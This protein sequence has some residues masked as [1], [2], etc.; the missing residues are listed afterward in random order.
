[1]KSEARQSIPDECY[2]KQVALVRTGLALRP[3]N[4]QSAG[5]V[6]REG[7]I[8]QLD[9]LSIA[10]YPELSDGGFAFI[11]EADDD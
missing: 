11:E 10:Q 1:M 3:G 2:Y 8:K 6:V 5:A 9:G 7:H 4:Q